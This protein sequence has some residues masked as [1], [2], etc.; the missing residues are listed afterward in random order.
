MFGLVLPSLPRSVCFCIILWRLLE[1]AFLQQ[2]PNFTLVEL[3]KIV[4]LIYHPG[5]GYVGYVTWYVVFVASS[6]VGMH[7]RE[8]TL[9]ETGLS[10]IEVASFWAVPECG[11]ERF[12]MLVQS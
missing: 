10:F 1:V 4:A 11:R 6:Y 12:A 7:A 8:P 2:I 3:E 9:L 5:E